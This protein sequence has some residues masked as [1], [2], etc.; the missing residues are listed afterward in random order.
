M[1]FAQMASFAVPEGLQRLRNAKAVGAS[2][3]DKTRSADDGSQAREIFLFPIAKA[4]PDRLWLIRREG[5]I[6][7]GRS[8]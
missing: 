8:K 2:L 5:K 7:R 6:Q 1:L 3:C 4:E